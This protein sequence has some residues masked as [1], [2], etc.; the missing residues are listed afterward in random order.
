VNFSNPINELPKDNVK[1]LTDFVLDAGQELSIHT[2]SDLSP[3]DRR[4]YK[5]SAVQ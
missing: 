5:L 2:G 1:G 4:E 3:H